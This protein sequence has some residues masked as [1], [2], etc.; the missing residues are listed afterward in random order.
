[1]GVRVAGD[2]HLGQVGHA[3]RPV[4]DLEGRPGGVV[5]HRHPAHVALVGAVEAT[6]PAPRNAQ[7]L[8]DVAHGAVVRTVDRLPKGRLL[9]WGGCELGG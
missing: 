7:N 4:L 9:G 8:A 6:L 3:L 5:P 1:M 2:R